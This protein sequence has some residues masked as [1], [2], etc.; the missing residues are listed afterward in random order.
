MGGRDPGRKTSAEDSGR[1]N[2]YLKFLLS[3]EGEEC[4]VLPHL[5]LCPASC[6]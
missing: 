5:S 1:V 2:I 6:S 3:Q 4:P